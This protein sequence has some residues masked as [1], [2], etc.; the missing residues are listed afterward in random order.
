MPRHKMRTLEEL[1]RLNKNIRVIGFDDAPFKR[2]QKEP[3]KV[4]GIVCNNTRF[5]GML[6]T[7]VTQDG[8]DVNQVLASTI[9]QSKFYDQ[10]N[11]VIFDGIAMG[12]FN[13]IDLPK[14]SAQLSRPC[15]SVMRKAP[16]QIAIDN[17]LRNF[18]DYE[19]RKAAIKNAGE[20]YSHPPFYF[21]C[22]GCTESIAHQTLV[23]LT[24]NGHVPESLRL[25]HLIGA[26]II[27]GQSSNRA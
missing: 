27:N 17:A 13:I 24:D 19:T 26:A 25:A 12:G 9:L 1:I 5:E 8:D 21:Q 10:I 15:I 11:V 23:K 16:D 7:K 4:A 22:Y 3:V 20:V 2:G 18:S 14:L 6:W